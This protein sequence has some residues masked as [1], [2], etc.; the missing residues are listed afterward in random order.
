M[1][2]HIEPEKGVAKR[3]PQKI[4]DLAVKA[5][6]AAK[7]A[8]LLHENGLEIKPNADDKDTAATLA[9]SYAEDPEKLRKRLQQKGSPPHPSHPTHD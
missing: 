8:E 9:V 6:A 2:I 3:T 5:S 4:K 1:A 7:T